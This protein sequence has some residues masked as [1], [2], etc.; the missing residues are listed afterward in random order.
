MSLWAVLLSTLMMTLGACGDGASPAPTIS[1]QPGDTSAVAGSAATL[2]VTASGT[3]SGYQWQ[4]R[5]DGGASW[6]DIA[7]ATQASHTTPA[8]RMAHN[9]TRCRVIAS[10]A[11]ISVTSSTVTLSVTGAVVAPAITGSG[12]WPAMK[13]AARLPFF[14]PH[15]NST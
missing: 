3:D 8:T 13:N 11:G 1:V 6:R 2:S 14:R 9:G 4:S 15:R 5:S 7:A 10:A 12:S